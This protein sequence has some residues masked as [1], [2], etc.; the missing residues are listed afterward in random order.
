MLVAGE[1]GWTRSISEGTFD[2]TPWSGRGQPPKV[3]KDG[4]VD[5]KA[6]VAVSTSEDSGGVSREV[7]ELVSSGIASVEA[8]VLGGRLLGPLARAFVM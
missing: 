4:S 6:V 7:L 2:W 8:A 5:E 3:S 1:G